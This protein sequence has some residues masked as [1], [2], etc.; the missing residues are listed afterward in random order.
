MVHVQTQKD[1]PTRTHNYT[2]THKAPF[3]T[4]AYTDIKGSL[5]SPSYR[6][7]TDAL[8]CEHIYVYAIVC[9]M[10]A[11]VCETT[12]YGVNSCRHPW[13]L[14][15]VVTWVCV[16]VRCGCFLSEQ[17]RNNSSSTNNAQRSRTIVPL[18]VFVVV[19]VRQEMR[20]CWELWLC[21]HGA[22]RRAGPGRDKNTNHIL[23]GLVGLME[24]RN[25]CFSATY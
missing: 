20:S 19:V 2:Y 21:A 22:Y 17:L 24:M 3:R 5:F 23:A 6:Y 18:N 25:T 15:L 1:R 9:F 14:K 12:M 10:S 11:S 4:R 16:H 13:H 8:C 7:S